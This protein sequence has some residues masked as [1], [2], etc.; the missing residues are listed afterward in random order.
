[1]AMTLVPTEFTL[2]R[3]PKPSQKKVWKAYGGHMWW[4]RTITG[5]LSWANWYSWQLCK[6]ICIVETEWNLYR[7]RKL[8]EK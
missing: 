5:I 6:N 2:G 8:K 7:V 3:P 1:M 4:V